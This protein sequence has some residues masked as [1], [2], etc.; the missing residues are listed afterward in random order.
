MK[1]V[2][3]KFVNYK[4]FGE[5]DNF[6]YVNNLNTIIGK[7]ESGKS[8][9]LEGL[10]DIPY[11]D[12]PNEKMFQ[13]N[14]RKNDRDM[15]IELNFETIESEQFHYGNFKGKVLISYEKNGVYCINE[16]FGKY[17]INLDEYKKIINQIHIILKEAPI[18]SA[19]AKE[20]VKGIINKFENVDKFIYIE[21]DY[22]DKFI[23]QLNSTKIPKI[24][25]L[26]QLFEDM[27]NLLRNIYLA[28]PN[29]IKIE[30]VDL[31]NTYTISE[32][33][34]ELEEY[35]F[36]SILYQFFE[37]CGIDSKKLIRTMEEGEITK[38]RTCEEEIQKLI[39]K[40][41]VEVFNEFYSQEK[42]KIIVDVKNDRFDIIIKTT[43]GAYLKYTERSNGF[44]WYVSIFIQLKYK[45]KS[46][47][48]CI[49]LLDEPGVYLHANAQSELKKFLT[50]LS[51]TKYQII[52]TTHSPFMLDKDDLLSIRALIKDDNGIS[53]IYNKIT[54]I[55]QQEKS[56]YETITPVLYALGCERAH[57]LGPSNSKINIITE[58][59]T[60]YCYILGYYESIDNENPYNIIPSNGANDVIAISLIL[61]GWGN[62]FIILLDQD[63]KG[64]SIYQS[65]K[66]SNSLFLDRVIFVDSS[67]EIKDDSTYEIENLFSK[68]DLEKFGINNPDYEEKKYNYA[69]NLLTKVKCKEEIYSE[70]S[71]KKFCMLIEEIEKMNLK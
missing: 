36:D 5:E 53:H 20:K 21:P 67:K 3:V 12:M 35:N 29:F 39:E 59:V 28:F 55:P 50:E 32:L 65:L 25:E 57:S 33:K 41:F 43:D 44:K 38:I 31:K 2:G 30:N 16:E 11:I 42:L 19:E 45:K 48:N 10:C 24:L 47:G 54:T 9:L 64:K 66:D 49:L 51:D 22:Y 4:S 17:I 62:D 52:Y 23:K 6:L 68:E 34:E 60:D 56:K 27:G 63:K 61:F 37:I 18:N 40:N 15:K 26:V 46:F 1:L 7:N 70:E 58:G 13:K 8:N 69:S 14:N 71:K